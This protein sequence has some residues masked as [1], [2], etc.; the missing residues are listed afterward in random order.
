MGA[1]IF[2]ESHVKTLLVLHGLVAMVLVGSAGHLGWES[3][4]WLVRR[5]ARNAWLQ[6]THARVGAVLYAI[7]FALGLVIYPTY[8]VRVRHDVFDVS[9][10][11][12]TN[13]FDS[14]EMLAAFGLAAFA[15][16]FAMS[17]AVRPREEADRPM[18]GV[19]ATLGLLASLVVMYSA[20]VGLIL[21]TRRSV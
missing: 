10:P 8:R 9:M 11:W 12:A 4:L 13:L 5:K 21:V 7:Q 2:A 20:V 16:L 3:L 17:F 1:P 14:K 18:V 6:V 19:F 15:A